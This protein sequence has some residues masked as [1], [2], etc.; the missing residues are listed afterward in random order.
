MCSMIS[1]YLLLAVCPVLALVQ[2]S[3]NIVDCSLS[4]TP[5]VLTHWQRGMASGGSLGHT[6]SPAVQWL[7]SIF[8]SWN[9][10]WKPLPVRKN[11]FKES[12]KNHNL[13]VKG[14]YIL[15]KYQQLTSLV[16]TLGPC[17][18]SSIFIKILVEISSLYSSFFWI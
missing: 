3:H 7:A 1:Q 14:F 12:H 5:A 17:G 6:V 2:S 11:S 10:W 8:L 18:L 4:P 13:I 15:N 16:P 9:H